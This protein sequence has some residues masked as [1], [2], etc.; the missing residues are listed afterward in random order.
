MTNHPNRSSLRRY[1]YVCPRG[2]AN[3]ITYIRVRPDDVAA[4]DAYF[5]S[6]VDRQFDA[7]YTD[8]MCGWVHFNSAEYEA[9]RRPGVAVDWADYLEMGG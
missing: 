9:A 8:A 2:F 1:Y 5:E 6:Y 3:E 7:G 4:V